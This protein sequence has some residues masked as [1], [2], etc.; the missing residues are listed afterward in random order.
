VR[1]VELGGPEAPPRH[2]RRLHVEP[3]ARRSFASSAR[4]TS[5]DAYVGSVKNI[6]AVHRGAGPQDRSLEKLVNAGAIL[7]WGREQVDLVSVSNQD[8]PHHVRALHQRA[9]APSVPVLLPVP[10]NFDEALAPPVV[11]S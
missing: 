6:K 1:G 9:R 3:Y 4:S 2:H 8:L 11:S 10:T 5:P 7:R